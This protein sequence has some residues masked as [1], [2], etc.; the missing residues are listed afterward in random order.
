M[1][2]PLFTGI[3]LA[4]ILLMEFVA[5]FTHKYLMHGSLWALH[6][7]HHRARKS[8]FELNDL[9]GVF[10]AF[11]SIP[12]IYLGLRFEPLVAAFGIG[13]VG[14]GLIYFFV[15]DILV[16]HRVEHGYVPKQGYM[17]RIYQGHRLHHALEERDGAVSFGFLY[18]AAPEQ[19]AAQ[20]KRNNRHRRIDDQLRDD[21][22]DANTLH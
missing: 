2:W 21:N 4:T 19:L 10:F 12:L 22:L 15:H 5:W 13:M 7:S 17:R 20:L 11:V 18:T 3:V 14:Y 9:F 16:H 8:W 1:N 6:A